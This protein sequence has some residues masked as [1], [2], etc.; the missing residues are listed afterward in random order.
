MNHKIILGLLLLPFILL[1]ENRESDLGIE[2]K[3]SK[4]IKIATLLNAKL[5]TRDTNNLNFNDCIEVIRINNSLRFYGLNYWARSTN[6]SIIINSFISLYEYSNQFNRQLENYIF[7][8]GKGEVSNGLGIY[9]SEFNIYSG[10]RS[11]NNNSLYR[12]KQKFLNK[13][14]N[15]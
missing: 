1:S 6:D 13:V 4:F 8:V 2:I 9:Y 14:F 5:E 12:K 11:I 15:K 7:R 3:R 10:G